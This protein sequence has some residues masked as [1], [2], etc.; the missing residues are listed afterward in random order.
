[1]ISDLRKIW[2]LLPPEALAASFLT[3]CWMFLA[4]LM[5]IGG[6]GMLVPLLNVAINID[7]TINN[8]AVLQYLYDSMGFASTTAFFGFMAVAVFALF[9]GKSLLAIY[10]TYKQNHLA[11]RQ[12][13]ILSKRLL[14]SYLNTSYSLHL[15]SNSS[16]LLR[17]IMTSVPEVFSGLV[18]PTLT[19]CAQGIL[20]L[21][22]VSFLVA[23]NPQAT[24]IAISMLFVLVLGV[25]RLVR[26]PIRAIGAKTQKLNGAMLLWS[27]QSLSGIK[28]I[29][30]QGRE[31]FFSDQFGQRALEQSDAKAAYAALI[32]VPTR[33]IETAVVG[34]ALA[35]LLYLISTGTDLKSEIT[36]LAIFAVAFVRLIP[37]ANLVAGQLNR[38]HMGSAAVDIVYEEFNKIGREAVDQ[39]AADQDHQLRMHQEL[40]IDNLS[41]AY[42]ENEGAAVSCVS[43]RIP[44][45][46]ALAIVGESGAG[47][48]TL[49]DLIIGLLRPT[50][51]TISVDGVAIDGQERHWRKSLA[52]IPQETYLID[53]TLRRNIALGIAPEDC[54][55]ARI[56]R[57]VE[58]SCLKEFVDSLPEGL[59]TPMGER[60]VRMS[61]GQRQR[62]AIARA[63]Y[64]DPDLMV[65]DEATSALDNKT[66][67]EVSRS[68]SELKGE[69]TIIVIAHRLNSLKYCDRVLVMAKGRVEAL[70]TP[71]ELYETSEIYK[72]MVDRA[73]LD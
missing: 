23:F 38:I 40:T 66:E 69:K 56:D 13:A 10:V 59:D 3:F 62:I 36:T 21:T 63:L 73:R 6:L 65:I 9:L 68:I 55:D 22:V 41:F 8:Y 46:E 17:N 71:K 52:Y 24:V 37:S 57:V 2:F 5:E 12:I 26:G 61:G 20:G 16:L 44:K 49:A 15:K 32:Q 11:E 51:G 31:A 53:D 64:E 72:A 1:M 34:L 30:A 25:Q 33:L 4:A 50:S 70:G 48:S 47:K 54:D 29:K 58:M 14:T 42:E 43:L 27:N 45:G 35:W 19:I 18:L 28:M 67:A 60:G 7:E 39:I